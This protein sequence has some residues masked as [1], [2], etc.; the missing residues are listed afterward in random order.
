LTWLRDVVTENAVL[1]AL[2]L[3]IA[4]GLFT[5]LHGQQDQQQRAVAVN[6]VLRLPPDSAKRELMTPV[7]ASITLTLRGSARALDHLL[8]TNIPPVEVDVRDGQK[9][10][11]VFDDKM[12]ALPAD[13]EIALIDPPSIDL[14]WQ[15]VVTRQIPI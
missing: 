14:E 12:F 5:Y 4:L 15:D 9:E 10:S 3:L 13:V 6:V 8:Q 1:K 2:S 7:P 11:I